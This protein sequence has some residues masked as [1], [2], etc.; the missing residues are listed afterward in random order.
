MSCVSIAS[1][2]FGLSSGEL[3]G[4]GLLPRRLGG[5]GTRASIW[6]E[7]GSRQSLV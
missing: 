6:G 3:L 7:T 2:S 5:L 1:M 4:G